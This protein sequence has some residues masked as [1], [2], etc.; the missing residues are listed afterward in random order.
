MP[1]GWSSCRKKPKI[2]A[3]NRSDRA[4]R[5]GFHHTHTHMNYARV[6]NLVQSTINLSPGLPSYAIISFGLVSSAGVIAA[7]V[8][9]TTGVL[10]I[11]GALNVAGATTYS[12]ATTFTGA[13]T[14]SGGIVPASQV[15]S[16]DGAITIKSGVVTITKGTAAVIT[17]AAP[18]VTTD[19]FKSLKIE[20]TTAAAHTVT[21][22]S[23]G[24]NNGSTASDVA[25][26]GAAIANGFELIAYQGVWYT[27]GTAKGVTL[28]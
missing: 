11:P 18:T 7:Y 19:D 2:K 3:C 26:F 10:T 24:F 12:G 4:Q 13:V 16:A 6:A 23:P 5:A 25:T 22:T 20:S 14:F 15:I 9:P 21:N 1:G 27:F 28:A 8:N 17:L